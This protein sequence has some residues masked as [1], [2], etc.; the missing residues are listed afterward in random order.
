MHGWREFLG[1]VGIIVLGVLIALAAEQL[2]ETLHWHREVREFRE[3]IDRELSS[4]LDSYRFRMEQEGCLKRRLA[5]LDR[6]LVQ[7]RAG[8]TVPLP[9]LGR[10]AMFT[11]GSNIWDTRGTDVMAHMP[12]ADR[13]K[14]SVLYQDMA[15]TGQ[16]MMEER[17]AWLGLAAYVGAPD[18]SGSDL[19]RF[20]GL[21][22]RAKVADTVMSTNWALVPPETA[23]FHLH[24]SGENG[25]PPSESAF[26]RSLPAAS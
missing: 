20:S 23:P 2:V 16:R 21:L 22:N 10:P 15:E 26:C 7:A 19:I 4:E 14:Y 6:W 24:P 13:L 8:H 11:M 9:E 18:V 12:L 5:T 25:H 3:A 17:E 1:E